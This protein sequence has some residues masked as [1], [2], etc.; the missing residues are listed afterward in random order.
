[1]C[2]CSQI[3]FKSNEMTHKQLSSQGFNG[4]S[5][6]IVDTFRKK[7]ENYSFL[8]TDRIG[9]GFSSIVYRGVNELTSNDLCK[10]R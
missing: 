5:A 9:K 8:M 10:F 1:L 3:K 4:N 7:I 2:L 6:Q